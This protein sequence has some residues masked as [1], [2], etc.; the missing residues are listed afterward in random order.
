MI[1]RAQRLV[2]FH[3]AATPDLRALVRMRWAEGDTLRAE[4]E[5]PVEAPVDEP[6]AEPSDEPVPHDPRTCFCA[7]AGGGPCLD[8]FL[9][10][11]AAREARQAALRL[12]IAP[13]DDPIN[14]APR[15]RAFLGLPDDC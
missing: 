7:D 8:C 1:A 10:F 2:A 3:A 14:Y 6:D 12:A 13:A 9:A 4:I 5:E 11:E 15:W